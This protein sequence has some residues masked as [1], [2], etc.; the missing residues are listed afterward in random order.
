MLCTLLTKRSI[1]KLED[2]A[3]TR[4]KL[5]TSTLSPKTNALLSPKDEK[6]RAYKILHFKQNKQYTH[7]YAHMENMKQYR[8]M[9][10]LEFTT[11]MAPNMKRTDLIEKRLYIHVHNV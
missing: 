1:D 3:C 6:R 8:T 9:V 4:T 5:N 10:M 2:F 7:I 11:T